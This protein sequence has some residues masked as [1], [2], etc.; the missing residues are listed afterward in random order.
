[1]KFSYKIKSENGLHGRAAARIVDKCKEYS[2]VISI[3]Y[4]GRIGETDSIISLT[5]LQ[6]RQ[7]NTLNIIIDGDDEV[8]VY[9]NF[10]NFLVETL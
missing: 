2:S 4:N 6:A 10:K 1:M 5:A 3:I 9:N 7:G 8:L